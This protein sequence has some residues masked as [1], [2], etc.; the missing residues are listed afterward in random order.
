MENRVGGGDYHLCKTTT[1]VVNERMACKFCQ[2]LIVYGKRIIYIIYH[3]NIRRQ[4]TMHPER[5]PVIRPVKKSDSF[6]QDVFAMLV[7]S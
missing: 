2:D 5:S 1:L 7:P 3:G 4:N 6:Q